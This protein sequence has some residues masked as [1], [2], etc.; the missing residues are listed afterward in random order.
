MVV[1]ERGK[2]RLGDRLAMVE[3]VRPAKARDNRNV[4]YSRYI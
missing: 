1:V 3:T 2:G 4:E